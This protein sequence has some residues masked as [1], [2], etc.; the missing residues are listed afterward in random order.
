MLL[1][2]RAT[3]KIYLKWLFGL[4]YNLNEVD[5][6]RVV[7]VFYGGAGMFRTR[8]STTNN[9]PWWKR[10]NVFSSAMMIHFGVY[11]TSLRAIR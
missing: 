8:S 6:M 3:N 7:T 4:L 11:D 10:P 9:P 5:C 2:I 1:D